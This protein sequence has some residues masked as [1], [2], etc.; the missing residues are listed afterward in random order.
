MTNELIW[1]DIHKAER[2]SEL[3]LEWNRRDSEEQP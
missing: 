2:L 3:L 1:C